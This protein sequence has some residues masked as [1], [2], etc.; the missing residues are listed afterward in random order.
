[1]FGFD[2]YI[3]RARLF[4]AIL[5]VAPALALGFVLVVSSWQSFGMPQVLTTA[6]VAVLFFGFS[7]LARRSGRRTERRL[8]ASSGGRPFPMVLRH[9]DSI[10]D[11]DSKA[12]Y[13]AYLSKKIGNAPTKEEEI[14][15]PAKA[16]RYYV[17]AGNWLRER[18]R[19][20]TKFK[21][22]FEENV[23]YGYRRNLYGLKW[24]GIALN[25]L[26]VFAGWW[27]LYRDPDS[28]LWQYGSV[29]FVAAIHALYFIFA[30]TKKSVI[31]ASQQ[32]GRQL[33]LA[34]ETLQAD[35]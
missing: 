18:T 27:F 10:I 2:S 15:D 17:R 12:D 30:I 24:A 19:D 34:I 25:A 29:F 16:D 14:D 32:Y 31:E 21:V 26:V 23:I 22:L 13:Y 1:M 11:E 5:A 7:D 8:F 3:L 33:V 4:P 35:T 6:A 20:K 9:S 28:A